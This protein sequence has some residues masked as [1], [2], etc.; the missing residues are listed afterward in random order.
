MRQVRQAR[1]KNFREERIRRANEAMERLDRYYAKAPGSRAFQKAWRDCVVAIMCLP[2]DVLDVLGK[3][4][5][6]HDLANAV[7]VEVPQEVRRVMTGEAEGEVGVWAGEI[8]DPF[9]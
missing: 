9:D 8:G 3:H 7:G 5:L 6:V 4:K 2:P 1:G